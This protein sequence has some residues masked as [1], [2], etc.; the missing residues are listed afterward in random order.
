MLDLRAIKAMS[1]K[2]T[3]V[4]MDDV[5]CDEVGS[6]WCKHPTDAWQSL[7]A[8][9]EVLEVGCLTSTDHQRSMCLGNFLWPTSGKSYRGS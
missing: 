6:F 8:A 7:I 4:L 3:L 2:E 5:R 1:H 9:G